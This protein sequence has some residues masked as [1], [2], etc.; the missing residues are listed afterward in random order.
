MNKLSN[1]QR[2][3]IDKLDDEGCLKILEAFVSYAARDY[4]AAFHSYLDNKRD[5]NNYYYYIQAREFFLSDYFHDL[6]GLFGED[7]LE[8]LDAGVLRGKY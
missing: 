6:T 2:L 4:R 5:K 8:M 7:I 1:F 3:T